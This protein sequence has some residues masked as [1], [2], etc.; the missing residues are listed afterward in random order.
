M[1]S[2]VEMLSGRPT[3]SLVIHRSQL[4]ETLKNDDDTGI[5]IFISVTVHRGPD[6][7]STAELVARTS[8]ANMADHIR[9]HRVRWLGHGACSPQA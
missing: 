3:V 6:G 2:L 9:R 8:Q 7:P 5:L 4:F 1:R